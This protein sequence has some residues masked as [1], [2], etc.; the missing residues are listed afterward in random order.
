M[1]P[2]PI[3]GM[4]NFAIVAGKI[5]APKPHPGAFLEACRLAGAA[6]HQVRE[7][8]HKNLYKKK[9]S[10]L[11]GCSSVKWANGGGVNSASSS[12]FLCDLL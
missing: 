8:L 2:Q 6:P 7:F 10:P 9:A 12:F 11:C 1:L 5:G 4:L 3:K